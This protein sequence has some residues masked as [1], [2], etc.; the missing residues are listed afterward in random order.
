MIRHRVLHIRGTPASGKTILRLLLTRHIRLS[1]P[2][3]HITS[4]EVWPEGL[5]KDD[6]VGTEKSIESR[7]SLS[8]DEWPFA[9]DR[10]F[11]VDEAQMTYSNIYFWNCFLKLIDYTQGVYVVL[12]SSYGSPGGRPVDLVNVTPPVL[13]PDQRISLVWTASPGFDPVGLLFTREEAIEVVALAT[14]HHQDTPN[15]AP[16]LLDWLYD[17]STGHAGA[18]NSLIQILLQ[19]MYLLKIKSILGV[20]QGCEATSKY[21]LSR[22]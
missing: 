3:W 20:S 5:Q 8:R 22:R 7:L 4:L 1:H 12:F 16:E 9:Q 2:N 11:L 13:R 17:L 15:F 10:V 6:L 18:L 21:S 19:G 14:E